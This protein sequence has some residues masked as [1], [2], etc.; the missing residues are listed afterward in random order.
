MA[1]EHDP[2]R[3]DEIAEIL[4]YWL[5]AVRFEEALTVRPKA[6]RYRQNQP[7]NL[8]EPQGQ[9][10]Y[11]KLPFN[12]ESLGFLTRADGQIETPVAGEAVPFTAQW[13]RRIYRRQRR[14]WK[15]DDN[16]FG[17]LIGW[18]TIYFPRGDEL[19]SLFRFRATIEW[20]KDGGQRFEPPSYRDRKAG[21]LPPG[22]KHINVRGIVDEDGGLMPYSLDDRL[23]TQTL[24]VADEELADLYEVLRGAESLTAGQ[25]VATVTDLLQS[26]GEWEPKL[27]TPEEEASDATAVE[28]LLDAIAARLNAGRRSP[29]VYPVGL[30]YDGA[31]IQTTHH[32]QRDLGLL[33]DRVRLH[34]GVMGQTPLG[35]YLTGRPEPAGWAPMMG[36][37][38]PEPLTEHQRTVAETFLGSTFS[39]A[40]GPPGTGKTRLIID[41]VAAE[42]VKRVQVLADTGR[43]GDELLVVASTNNR[44]VDNVFD[45]FDDLEVTLGIR[46][47]SQQVT[48]QR[49]S[50]QI[51]R[52]QQWLQRQP[53]IDPADAR[54]NLDAQLEVFSTLYQSL[55]DVEEGRH[56]HHRGLERRRVLDRRIAELEALV[57]DDGEMPSAE[58]L[59]TLRQLR[60]HLKA[61]A[62]R[63]SGLLDRLEEGADGLDRARAHFRK[64]RTQFEDGL[65]KILG[66]V[67]LPTRFTLPGPPQFDGTPG[68]FADQWADEVAESI[69]TLETL[70]ADVSEALKSRE[71]LENLVDLRQER[72]GLDAQGDGALEISAQELG[73]R[74]FRLFQQALTVRR[75]WILV[76]RD[77]LEVVIKSAFEAATQRRSLRKSLEPDGPEGRLLRQLF[78]VVGSTLLSMGN[79]FP[80]RGGQVDRLVIDEGG[81]CHPAYAVSGLMR[82]DSALIIGDVYQLEPV[83][84]LSLEDEARVQRAARVTLDVERLGPYR[85]VE[86]AYISAQTLADRAV[87]RRPTLTT[88]FR[89]QP[90]IIEICDALC[91]YGL[92]IETKPVTGPLPLPELNARVA[93]IPV[94]GSQE[95]IRGSWHNMAERDTV[96][97]L[98][99]GL[100]SA[101]VPWSEIAV[102]TPYV[103]QLDRIRDALRQAR[104]PWQGAQ[105]LDEWAASGP[106]GIAL[107]TV[108][109]FQGG[110]RRVVLFSTVVSRPR[111]LSF[112]NDRVNLMNVA[113]SRA[114]EQLLVIGAPDILMQ[115][116]FTRVLVDRAVRIG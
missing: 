60:T 16:T 5:S 69:T 46:A 62:P 6:Y 72:D 88:H 84:Q 19:G 107:G 97:S 65:M 108:H 111:S 1:F 30:V 15:D 26:S 41:L 59:Q 47:G 110:E 99:M 93:L 43:M 38:H 68:G 17:G 78:P 61:L 95:R 101:G 55:L 70:R 98:L 45:A 54:L 112:L 25:M 77:Q 34:V 11:F 83:V 85:V 53:V 56:A 57:E 42:L 10:P 89:C 2:L 115:G 18:P 20:Q 100:Q 91:G 76:H 80:A 113:I 86:R 71:R 105:E 8:A 35:T 106:E 79:V 13:L 24:G 33:V 52:L 66:Q 67:E 36:Q 44:A 21:R 116:Q 28:G 4:R 73:R 94:T 96:I 92:E 23:L 104:I 49:T 12:A 37:F 90:E 81:Q 32:L 58:T 29:S 87:H 109:R 40:Q 14:R 31:Q 102:I 48:I 27:L 3:P 114:R 64:T 51:D 39:A 7:L 74:H 63:L 22:P 9:Q 50:A 82:S 103:G 75:A